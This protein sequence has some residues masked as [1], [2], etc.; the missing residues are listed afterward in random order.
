MLSNVP[1]PNQQ[2]FPVQ[3]E[4]ARVARAA[5]RE[6]LVETCV[7]PGLLDAADAMASD[8][9]QVVQ[10]RANLAD[11]KGEENIIS[12]RKF[13]ASSHPHPLALQNGPSSFVVAKIEDL[14]E[15][16][17]VPGLLDAADAM[18]SDLKQVPS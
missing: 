12:N 4:G 10:E 13:S 14:V 5:R 6:D 15:T 8:L 16:C 2:R 11:V 3:V 17:V 1:R 18:A 9:K 7:V